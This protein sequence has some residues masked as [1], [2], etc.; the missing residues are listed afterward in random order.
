[1][2]TIYRF[3]HKSVGFEK[4]PMDKTPFVE[5]FSTEFSTDEFERLCTLL[6]PED[7]IIAG[8]SVLSGYHD[9][10]I[11][12][13]DIYI[14]HHKL[15]KLHEFLHDLE[16]RY[17]VPTYN[18]SYGQDTD[19]YYRICYFCNDKKPI[20]VLLV[21]NSITPISS[22]PTNFDLTFCQIWFD[23]TDVHSMYPQTSKE[24]RLIELYYPEYSRMDVRTMRR[25]KKYAL[26]G[27]NITVPPLVI[28]IANN[29]IQNSERWVRYHLYSE[30]MKQ[31]KKRKKNGD[32]KF[33]IRHDIDQFTALQLH[34]QFGTRRRRT[35]VAC[36]ILYGWD[37]CDKFIDWCVTELHILVR[38]L[39]YEYMC[40]LLSTHHLLNDNYPDVIEYQD[41]DES[42]I[43]QCWDPIALEQSDLA[44]R[45]T[46]IK[47]DQTNNCIR[48]PD[49][50]HII[51]DTGKW[52]FSCGEYCP[53]FYGHEIFIPIPFGATSDNDVQL[54]VHVR[55]RAI[56]AVLNSPIT[57]VHVYPSTQKIVRSANFD[58]KYNTSQRTHIGAN[59]GQVGTELSLYEI[60]A[61]QG[62]HCKVLAV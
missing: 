53:D 11:A 54:N 6:S 37:E 18:S 60:V 49:L 5:K 14:H 40:N 36:S 35:I 34:M 32:I 62:T 13:I 50:M 4:T 58:V 12:D 27:F 3:L 9:F 1:M 29:Q 48:V 15:R 24:G 38:P 45:I 46:F 61:C 31:F 28:S 56:L 16:Y 51:K 42:A 33:L 47:P 17:Y 10:D 57:I 52:F 41:L 30:Y 44:G 19:I 25:I 59:H 21:K 55:L 7:A 2:D 26:R 20:D 43:Q 23:G 39:A 22:I 8:G